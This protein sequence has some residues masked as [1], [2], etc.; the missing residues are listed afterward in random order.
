M[1]I[2]VVGLGEAGQALISLLDGVGHDI[3]VIDKN[4]VCVDEM[5]DRFCVN[6]VVGSGASEETLLKAGAD[7][8]DVLIALTHTDEINLISCMQA[9]A[10]GTR[11]CA[12]R[13]LL[14][15]L[16]KEEK[17]IRRKYGIDFIVK[18]K[19]D[20]AGEIHRNIGLPGYVKLECCVGT[21]LYV[22]DLNAVGSSPLIGRTVA[23][24]REEL[25]AD[26]KISVVVRGR[27]S[28]KP[29]DA[30]EIRNGDTLYI[31][32]SKE[33]LD[34]V[35]KDLQIR[36]GKTKNV[37]IVGGH[38]TSVYLI[39]RLLADHMSV[40]VLDDDIERCR[41]LMDRFPTINVAYAEGDI[42]EVLEEEKVEK[43]DALVSLTDDDDT[44]LVISMFAW[45]K[46]IYSVITRV[47]K[48]VHV[49]LLH[50]VNIDITVSPTEYSVFGLIRFITAAAQEDTDAGAQIV[51]L[52]RDMR[53]F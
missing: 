43:A 40:T 2:L 33:H 26:A 13:L 31:V 28:L 9:K 1:K 25:T 48:Q 45:S 37:V 6:G 35:L 12:A 51:E 32:V 4:R 20:I 47:D 46:G 5:T 18:P 44:N 21:D 49:K 14:P 15:D 23:G 8:A 16:V 34:K 24:I 3:T 52:I 53:R 10:V 50:K 39:E 19:V 36:R 41:S 7:T 30:L 17:A 42:T 38:T 11:L 29:N 27:K 22:I